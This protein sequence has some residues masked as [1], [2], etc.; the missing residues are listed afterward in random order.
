MSRNIFSQKFLTYINRNIVQTLKVIILFVGVCLLS[1][2]TTSLPYKYKAEEF[3]KREKGVVVFNISQSD[4]G[5]LRKSNINLSYHLKRLGEDGVYR[6]DV[7]NGLF[8][9][10]YNTHSYSDSILMLEPGIYYI[11]HVT[12]C[13]DG[14]TEYWLPSPGIE[15][16]ASEQFEDAYVFK[17]GAFKVNAGDVVYPGHLY[18]SGRGTYSYKN[19]NELEKAKTDLTNGNHVILAQQLKPTDF[20]K[21]GSL[22][23][24]ESGKYSLI[25]TEQIEQARKKF[26]DTVFKR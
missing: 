21:N 2:C 10:I 15:R 13:G 1:G 20:Y 22:Y 9:G 12:L 7:K 14:N 17:Y 3:S 24:N 23:L 4:T 25:S 8:P 6:V 26:V 16:I 11:D 18:I 19:V 5:L